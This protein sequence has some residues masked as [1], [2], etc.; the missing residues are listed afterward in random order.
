MAQAIAFDTVLEWIEGHARPNLFSHGYKAILP[1]SRKHTFQVS[2]GRITGGG[3]VIPHADC[4]MCDFDNIYVS[5]FV[6]IESTV[7]I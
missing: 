3:R 1:P 4:P 5:R 2:V 6:C 7:E